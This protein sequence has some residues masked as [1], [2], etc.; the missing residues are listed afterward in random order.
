[1][2]VNAQGNIINRRNVE[3]KYFEENL[4]NNITLEMVQIPGGSFRMGSPADEAERF[5]NEGPQHEGTIPEFFMGRY[6]VTQAQY[7]QV[8]GENPSRFKGENRPVEQVSWNNAME[9]CKKLSEVTGRTYR[10]PSEAEWEYACRA[11]TTTPFHFGETITTDLVNYNGNSTYA[12]APKGE[13]RQQTTDVGIFFP[14]FFGLYEMHGNVL[15]WC[16]DTWHK[17]YQGAPTDGS[18]WIDEGKKN[19]NLSLDW[20]EI[21]RFYNS[22]DNNSRMLRGSSWLNLSKYCRSANSD[23]LVPYGRAN[24]ISFRLVISAARVLFSSL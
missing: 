16:L 5:V 21:E 20:K 8:M 24:Y 3:A 17:N 1:M 19:L 4:G 13:Y 9:F 12:S 7:Q 11:G 22:L 23:L 6:A 2:T 10:L 15:E 18:A 14:N